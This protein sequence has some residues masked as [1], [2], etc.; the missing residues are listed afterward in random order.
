MAINA[1]RHI[2]YSAQATD[3][4]PVAVSIN[5]GVLH[6]DP[7]AKYAVAFERISISSFALANS[8]RS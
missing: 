2:N 6:R 7:F 5:P 4:V 3:A 8:L 1:A